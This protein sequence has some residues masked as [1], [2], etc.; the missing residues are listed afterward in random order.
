MGTGVTVVHA[1]RV[2]RGPIHRDKRFVFVF[3]FKNEHKKAV[4]FFCFGKVEVRGR[5]RVR[6]ANDFIMHGVY[7]Y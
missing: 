1:G 5:F 6:A 4:F 2:I 3:V 7:V